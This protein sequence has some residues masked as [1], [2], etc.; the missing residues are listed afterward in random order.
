MVIGTHIEG[1]KDI[2]KSNVKVYAKPEYVYIPLI[3]GNDINIDIDVKKGQHIYKG[4]VVAHKKNMELPIHSS[5]SGKVVDFETKRVATREVKCI[6]IAN[7]FKE[8]YATNIEP[9]DVIDTYTKEEFIKLLKDNGIRGLGGADFPTYVK[10]NTVELH[11]LIINAVECEPYITAD[12]SV[13]MEHI[14]EILE[15]IKAIMKINNIS[16]GY[17]A[18]KRSNS[19]VIKLLTKK[20]D[21]TSKIKIV[22]VPDLYPMGWEKNIV[23]YILK[24]TYDKLPN[25]LNTVISNVSTIYAIYGAL[26]FNRPLMSRIVTITGDMIKKPFNVDVKIGTDLKEVLKGNVY[27]NALLVAG[28]PMMGTSVP[29]ENLIVTSN[30]NCLLALE[31]YDEGV[32]T[33]CLRCGKCSNSCPALLSPVMIKDNIN[34]KEM[35]KELNVSKC[36]GC[37]LCSYVCPAKINVRDYVTKAKELGGK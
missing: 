2:S 11:N 23:N 34:N 7:D 17:I 16:N 5:I 27:K 28:G 24:K 29:S 18:V 6:K 14:D 3:V 13:M 20:V 30:L 8:E 26:K 21:T 31:K 10:Y 1:H 19:E 25:E 12:Y 35:L 22:P 33:P 36:I 4:E 9:K 15:T 37:G 32:P